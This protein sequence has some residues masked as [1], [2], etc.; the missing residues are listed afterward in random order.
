MHSITLIIPGLLPPPAAVT[1]TDLPD[2]KTLNRWLARSD[3][4]SCQS[5]YYRLLFDCFGIKPA[6]DADY[7]I[8]PLAYYA[9]TGADP[10]YCMRADPVHLSPGRE[11]LILVDD[12]LIGI[13]ADEAEVLAGDLRPWIGELGAELHTPNPARWYLA[14]PEPPC[15]QTVPLSD[16]TGR[17]ISSHL[18]TGS[19]QT[20]W[21]QFFNELQMV[22]H[23]S[24][25]NRERE[26][27]GRH[28]VNSLWFWGGGA[29]PLAGHA[30]F[31]SCFSD[32]PFVRGLA[33]LHD[34]SAASLPDS[35]EELLRQVGDA[36]AVLVTDERL[37][38]HQA[39]DN[40]AVWLGYLEALERDWMRPLDQAIWHGKLR[41]LNII[42]GGERFVCR[43]GQRWRFWRREG[44]GRVPRRS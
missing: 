21:R 31:D 7:P 6:T 39:Y 34:T 3:R 28:T 36:D 35:A 15:I 20:R 40:A 38:Q 18:P 25:V 16:V 9:E 26:K 4:R 24:A 29:L 11:G 13:Q 43:R 22:L 42:T 27:R 37:R 30:P 32:D 2:C 5:D 19:E 41:Q 23:E 17:D 33:L 10:G 1:E 14:F 12:S 8:A 44:L